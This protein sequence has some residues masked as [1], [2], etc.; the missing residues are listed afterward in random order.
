MSLMSLNW[1]II[2][3]QEERTRSNVT[4]EEAECAGEGKQAQAL[5][6]VSSR[7]RAR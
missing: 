7:H 1:D 4:E 2:Q 6:V 3:K 5:A